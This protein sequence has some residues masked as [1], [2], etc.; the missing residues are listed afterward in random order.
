[1]RADKGCTRTVN[2]WPPEDLE[3]L[4]KH[5]SRAGAEGCSRYLPGRDLKAIGARA[6]K[7]GLRYRPLR[8]KSQGSRVVYS[9]AEKTGGPGRYCAPWKA[10]GPQ[11]YAKALAG[12]YVRI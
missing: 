12:R 5:F 3:V 11:D 7:L 9:G 6:N 10:M 2:P 4:R 1:M 8:R